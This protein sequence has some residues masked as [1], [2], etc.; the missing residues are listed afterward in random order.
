MRIATTWG[1]AVDT[2]QSVVL[3]LWKSTWKQ[4][5]GLQ[6]SPG[7]VRGFECYR[8]WQ[9]YIMFTTLESM[10]KGG[11]FKRRY[12][13]SVFKFCFPK[14]M[15]VPWSNTSFQQSRTTHRR[16]L[17]LI[18]CKVSDAGISVPAGCVRLKRNTLRWSNSFKFFS[19]DPSNF[20]VFFFF[21]FS[22]FSPFFFRAYL[23]SFCCAL[24]WFSRRISS[25]SCPIRSRMTSPLWTRRR[26]PSVSLLKATHSFTC[27]A[28]C[29]KVS[30]TFLFH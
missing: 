1:S 10:G 26:C 18:C 7:L 5:H 4:H 28:K 27:R 30:R 15:G 16:T 14:E 11:R 12:S 17:G 8:I 19:F 3:Q 25:R 6:T 22:P 29:T 2:K 9:F 20:L 13:V 24:Q 23:S 21:F